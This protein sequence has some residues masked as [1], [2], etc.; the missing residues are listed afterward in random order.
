M[1]C[2]EFTV[3]DHIPDQRDLEPTK[4]ALSYVGTIL[5]Q[6]MAL[7]DEYVTSDHRLQV[8]ALPGTDEV[9]ELINERFR[10]MFFGI[11]FF[12]LTHSLRV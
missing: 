1:W 2:Q 5:G 8:R 10:T 4:L 11:D 7:I 12:A 9:Q 6:L 3:F